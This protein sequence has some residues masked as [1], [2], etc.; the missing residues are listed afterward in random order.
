[1]LCLAAKRYKQG[2]EVNYQIAF[3]T[4]TPP[5][6]AKLAKLSRSYRLLHL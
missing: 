2:I 4:F 3:E 1:M 6:S 5:Q